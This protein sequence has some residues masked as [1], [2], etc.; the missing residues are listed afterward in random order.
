MCNCC[1]MNWTKILWQ[2]LFLLIFF[3][4]VVPIFFFNTLLFGMKLVLILKTLIDDRWFRSTT[5]LQS[6]FKFKHL[7][8]KFIAKMLE[9]ETKVQTNYTKI[10]FLFIAALLKINKIKM[11][12]DLFFRNTNKNSFK[13]GCTFTRCKGFVHGRI[14]D[15][16]VKQQSL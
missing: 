8:L 7:F 1:L 6:H 14:S 11:V 13:K 16:I 12:W 4:N 10:N 2:I 5:L 3:W 15:S 9:F